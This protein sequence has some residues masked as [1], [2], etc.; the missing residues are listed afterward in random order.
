MLLPEGVLLYW[1][2]ADPTTE[3]HGED[4]LKDHDDGHHQSS[5]TDEVELLREELDQ[6]M[7]TALRFQKVLWSLSRTQSAGDLLEERSVVSLSTAVERCVENIQDLDGS[8][9]TGRPG[10]IHSLDVGRVVKIDQLFG[11]SVPVHESPDCCS[12]FTS[13]QDHQKEEER[14]QQALRF[15]NG[16]VTSEEAHKH[17]QSSNSYQ[18]VHTDIEGVGCLVAFKLKDEEVAGL[19]IMAQPQSH[20]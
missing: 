6:F 8:V 17:H 12:H 3:H 20:S 18:Y 13:K 19:T 7:V 15:L 4:H 5:Q 10:D 9:F 14:P 1:A 2:V 11:D 16:S